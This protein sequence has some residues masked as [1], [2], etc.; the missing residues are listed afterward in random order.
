MIQGP[1][2]RVGSPIFWTPSVMLIQCETSRAV[3]K[4]LSIDG[5]TQSQNKIWLQRIDECD[6]LCGIRIL[7]CLGR[8][9]CRFFQLFDVVSENALFH[10]SLGGGFTLELG[11]YPPPNARQK[12]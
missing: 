3:A 5:T 1:V 2:D 4:L 11:K 6:R 12:L 7:D 10:N 8:E 9:L